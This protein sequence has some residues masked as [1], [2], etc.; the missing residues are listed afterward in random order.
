MSGDSRLIVFFLVD[1][2]EFFT[3]FVLLLRAF[4]V[5]I[6]CPFLA[7]VKS[8]YLPDFDKLRVLLVLAVLEV[9]I[10]PLE[11]DLLKGVTLL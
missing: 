8:S 10:L 3:F 7:L 11:L 2:S 6:V 4:G 9:F 1:L 5:T